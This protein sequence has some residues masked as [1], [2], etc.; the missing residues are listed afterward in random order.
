MQRLKESGVVAM[1]SFSIELIEV[2][3]HKCSEKRCFQIL[4]ELTR[5]HAQRNTTS[6]NRV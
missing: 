1:E 4:E 6:D 5:Q 3:V 2:I